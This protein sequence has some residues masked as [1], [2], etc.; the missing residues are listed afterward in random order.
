MRI[1]PDH[2]QNVAE[3]MKWPLLTAKLGEQL[4]IYSEHG[5]GMVHV[6]MD[7]IGDEFMPHLFHQTNFVFLAF[8]LLIEWS[9]HQIEYNA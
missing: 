6:G 9:C 5:N 2:I 7:L 1:N 4:L 8:T 3:I